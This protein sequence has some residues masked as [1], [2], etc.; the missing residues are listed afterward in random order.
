M[1]NT[2]QTTYNDNNGSNMLNKIRGVVYC[3]VVV[4]VHLWI[5]MKKTK[6]SNN[7][8]ILDFAVFVVRMSVNFQS[9][10]KRDTIVSCTRIKNTAFNI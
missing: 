7:E 3:V 8:V 6:K 9:K 5:I 10:G 2:I 4:V 1:S